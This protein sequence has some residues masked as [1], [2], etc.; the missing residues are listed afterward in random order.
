M[1]PLIVVPTQQNRKYIIRQQQHNKTL[2]Q[3]RNPYT[4]YDMTKSYLV[5]QALNTVAK[6]TRTQQ[7]QA[8]A[9]RQQLQSSG[10]TQGNTWTIPIRGISSGLHK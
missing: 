9:R 6:R 5:K 4:T 8:E 1:A 2:N 7:Q 10:N 3:Q